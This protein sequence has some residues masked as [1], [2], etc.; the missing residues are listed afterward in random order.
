LC[1]P[2]SYF[3]VA[4]AGMTFHLSAEGV[5]PG[6]EF[7]VTDPV[8]TD[9]GRE[10]GDE[11]GVVSLHV[12][13]VAPGELRWTI[14]SSPDSA[15]SRVRGSVV[16]ESGCDCEATRYPIVLLHGMCG[17]D[18]YFGLLEYFYD[19]TGLLG[20]RGFRAYTPVVPT[21]GR[22]EDRAAVL[23]P[24]VDQILLETGAAKV[25]LIAHS[26]G[27]LDV[28]VLISALGYADR[29]ASVSTISSP[30]RG[31]PIDI[32]E[33]LAGDDFSRE[34]MADFARRFPDVEGM[35]FFSWAGHSCSRLK[36]D[37]RAAYQDEVIELVLGPSHALML[38]AA[39]DDGEHGAN[40]GVVLV[41][42]ARWGTFLGEI[43]A[44]HFDE[45]GQ[46]ADSAPAPF[47]H[48]AFYL[49]EARRLR[50]LERDRAL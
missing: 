3:A 44:D 18:R 14:A 43:P 34:G 1:G 22:S 21:I 7:S 30:H 32:P 17:T 16:C 11:R 29:V 45:V 13:T 42:S 39:A 47:D 4:A 49:S 33:W 2:L 15:P 27:G 41:S 36:G 26:Q 6:A 37:C 35:P 31:I 9:L 19:I 25:H 28:R 40:D 38:A 12:T 20:D 8:G 10:R 5:P 48:R 50:Q 24:Q 23:A 46:I